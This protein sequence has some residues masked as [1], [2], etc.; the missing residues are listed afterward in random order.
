MKKA[1]K[2]DEDQKESFPQSLIIGGKKKEQ[3]QTEAWSVKVFSPYV[4]C[5]DITKLQGKQKEAACGS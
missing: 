4:F 5:R 3:S 1:T 2:F